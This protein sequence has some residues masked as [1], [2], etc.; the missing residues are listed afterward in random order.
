MG[1]LSKFL[2]VLALLYKNTSSQVWDGNCLSDPFCVWQGIKQSCLLSPLLFCL[3]INDLHECLPGGV[4]VADT[5][6][7]V[8][9][10]A[11]D[12][13][14]LAVRSRIANNDK[15]TPQVL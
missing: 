4:N 11:D 14:I 7:K 2:R 3:Y 5:L 9:L 15:F 12:L 8:L 6:V 13:I 10:Y 1:I